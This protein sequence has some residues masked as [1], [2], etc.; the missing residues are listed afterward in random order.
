M[1]VGTVY[2]SDNLWAN[3]QESGH[4]WDIGWQLG[5]SSAWKPFFGP[6]LQPRELAS[7]QVGAHGPC[8]A[9]RLA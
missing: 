7:I 3:I 8:S 6:V 4:P 5:D 9:D 1:Q 2:S